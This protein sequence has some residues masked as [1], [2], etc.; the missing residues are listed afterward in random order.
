[1]DRKQKEPIDFMVLDITYAWERKMSVGFKTTGREGAKA[2]NSCIM[3]N[4]DMFTDDFGHQADLVISFESAYNRMNTGQLF[5]QYIGRACLMV[6]DRVRNGE[7]GTDPQHIFDVLIDFANDIRPL[8]AELLKTVFD[9]PEKKEAF[10]EAVKREGMRVIISSFSI[11]DMEKVVLTL[12]R[13]WK[14][15]KTCVNFATYV[16]GERKVLRSKS[17]IMIGPKYIYLL[18]KLPHYQLISAEFGHVSQFEMPIKLSNDLKKQSPYSRTP[19]RLGEDEYSILSMCI[20]PLNAARLMGLYTSSIK[21]VELL[22]VNLLTA[23]KPSALEDIPMSTTDIINSSKTVTMLTHMFGVSGVG[24]PTT[25][26]WDKY[27][28]FRQEQGRVDLI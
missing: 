18:G 23:E 5:E 11:K 9:I 24:T 20:T 2:V 3:K 12:Y 22:I 1:M 15:V 13:K 6:T 10:V 26:T 16:N 7:Y 17:P 14:I 21:A 8:Y 19:L 25:D 4:E 28:D 27:M